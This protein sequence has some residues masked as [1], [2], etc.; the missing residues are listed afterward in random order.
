MTLYVL[1]CCCN[2][3]ILNVPRILHPARKDVKYVISH[4]K[5]TDVPS[6]DAVNGMLLRSDVIYS[7]LNGLGLSRNRNNALEVCAQSAG[8]DDICLIADDDVEYPEDAFDTVLNAFR[9]NV[10][11]VLTF[12]ISTK[13]SNVPFKK[14]FPNA[15]DILK[16]VI[17]GDGYVSSIEI[18][19][20][21][22]SIRSSGICFDENF[23]LGGRLYPEGGEEA[24]FI[25]DCISN[26]LHVRYIPEVIVYHKYESSGKKQ[27]TVSK[28][29]MMLGVA[30]RVYGKFSLEAA[31]ARLRCL[32]RHILMK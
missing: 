21:I 22:S 2:S 18:A 17:R 29:R 24:V 1:I 8:N 31:I 6:D 5:T 15:H 7:S 30:E 20:R 23:G 28:A 9:A 25:S 26:G 11:D 3:S 32:Y 19:F 10:A 13:D 16:P 27:K 12:Q 14:Y 4:Q